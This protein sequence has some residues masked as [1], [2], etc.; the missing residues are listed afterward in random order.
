MVQ[1]LAPRAVS[2]LGGIAGFP[3]SSWDWP[4]F[5]ADSLH[6]STFPSERLMRHCSCKSLPHG[7]QN[8]GYLTVLSTFVKECFS[9][10]ETLF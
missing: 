6:Q 1:L 4:D 5:A 8:L 7:Q 3:Q 2:F 10:H 9:R